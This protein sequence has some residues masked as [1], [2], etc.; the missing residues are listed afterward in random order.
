MLNATN[1]GRMWGIAG[2]RYNISLCN[3]SENTV[4]YLTT[5][6]TIPGV[7]TCDDDGCGIASGASSV[8]FVPSATTTYRIYIF[9]TSFGTLYP[10]PTNME[11][12][13]TCISTV[14]PPNDDPCGAIALPIDSL[15]NYIS[16]TNEAATNSQFVVP[17]TGP[18]PS[19][20]GALY[21]G[22]DVWYT[23][24][25]P[26]NGLI[27]IQTEENTICSGAF[28]LYIAS[29]CNGTFTQLAGSCIT[30]GLTGPN[31]VPAM[32][33]D[34]FSAGLAPGQTIYI[35]YWE[36]NGNEN[37]TFGICAFE[38][39]SP[40]NDQPCSPT[41]LPLNTSCI[42]VESNYGFSYPS[43]IPSPG[44]GGNS[45]NDIW[46]SVTVP[47]PLPA[48]WAGMVVE[49]A[50]SSPVNLAMAWYRLNGS[51]CTPADLQL[52]ACDPSG[53]IN[54]QSIPLEL[55]PGE[56]IYVRIWGEAPW[57]GPFNICAYMNQAPPNDEPCGAIALPLN[58][59]C[60][61][62]SY[63][64]LAATQT[65]TSPPGTI[66]VPVPSCG[67]QTNS[68]VWFT[69][70]VPPNGTVQLDMQAS[71]L[72][73]AAMAAYRVHSGTCDTGDLQLEEIACAV[74]GSQ[75][76]TGN[77]EMPYLNITDEIPGSTLY[78]R[79]WRQTGSDGPFYLCARRIDPPP[80]NCFYT[81]HLEDDAG[82]GWNGSYVT[83]CIG[84]NCVNYTVTGAS[85]TINIGVNVG[86]Q[87]TVSYT[88]V[89]GFQGENSFLISQ[90]GSP[91][92]VSASPPQSGMVMNTTVACN[93]PP[94]P[95]GDCLGA[96]HLCLNSTVPCMPYQGSN[97]PD[98]L[99][100]DNSGC[101]ADGEVQGQW[102]L[103][104]IDITTAPCSPLAF[105]IVGG[106]QLGCDQGDDAVFDFAVW[107]PFPPGSSLSSICSLDQQPARCNYASLSTP[108]IKGLA[109]DN[110][111][112]EYQ[113]SAGDSMAKHLI[114]SAC[115]RLLLFVNNR[116]STGQHFQI[117]W[118]IPPAD[119]Q[120]STLDCPTPPPS[121]SYAEVGCP[122][123]G[124]C[125]PVL[126]EDPSM[127]LNSIHPNPVTD[128]LRIDQ[129]L[130]N[131]T[132]YQIIDPSGRLIMTGQ[133]N[134]TKNDI[135]VAA[136]DAGTYIIKLGSND[137]SSVSTHRFIKQ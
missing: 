123:E 113:N 96:M 43:T 82:N 30:T 28:Q 99:T 71:A 77:S 16:G 136:L 102:F 108:A 116:D 129:A 47:N 125:G 120:V 91:I 14:P 95:N 17:G 57:Q 32:V 37:G 119:F 52:L 56:T 110:D 83:I 35:R 13:I 24:T 27:G 104:N 26:A 101:L 78:I 54:S 114:V 18:P 9:N 6:T 132:N 86:Q 61:M 93:P 7:I 60:L 74:N 85:T 58:Y 135:Q 106:N 76:G 66:D 73:D 131:I 23:V 41:P 134:S 137:D 65:S 34:A 128:I 25:V 103:I 100:P 111:L 31:S 62:G 90:Y 130:P 81:L 68:D 49:T 98:D 75:Q 127:S 121:G 126:V 97:D 2:N 72:T 51:P 42:P 4:L 8:S 33:F 53:T 19:C 109:F 15:C 55:F 89:G 45:I 50:A 5:N 133:F 118:K 21:Q 38:V 11:V 122:M 92:Y 64:N 94:A 105:D 29:A 48:D 88:A 39:D 44:C 67:G 63:T 84:G 80:G 70:E 112:P 3:N 12:V 107:G 115:D 10:N 22:A 117:Q 87:F 40:I 79:I 20:T 46:Y 69:V 124:G 59:G 1:F 36:R